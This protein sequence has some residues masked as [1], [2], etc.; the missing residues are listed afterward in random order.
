MEYPTVVMGHRFNFRLHDLKWI[1][2]SHHSSLPALNR[3]NEDIK[4]VSAKWFG[5]TAEKLSHI[6]ACSSEV[7]S[8]RWKDPDVE[9]GF[10]LSIS[11]DLFRTR[12]ARARRFIIIWRACYVR[13]AFDGGIEQL[14]H[15]F[16][17]HQSCISIYTVN[18]LLGISWRT[19]MRLQ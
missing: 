5:G 4:T 6:R 11:F 13:G 7:K 1:S 19:F 10:D 8:I 2:G 12:K 3:R 16:N 15:A 18:T 17:M 14:H 9:C